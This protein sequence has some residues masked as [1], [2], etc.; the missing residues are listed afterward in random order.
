MNKAVATVKNLTVVNSMI[1]RYMVKGFLLKKKYKDPLEWRRHAVKYVGQVARDML[2]FLN[3]DI[4]YNY[5]RPDLFANGKKYFMVCNHMSYMDI[6]FLSAGEDAVFV[7]SVE[8][9]NTPFLGDIAGFGVSYFVE[10]RDRS[11][12]PVDGK[13]VAK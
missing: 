10:R 3:F 7:T 12:G 11:K 13:D 5:S 8:M 9:Q 1:A 6:P 2:K 4:Q